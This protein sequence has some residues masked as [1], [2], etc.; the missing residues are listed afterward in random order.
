VSQGGAAHCTHPS[1]TVLRALKDYCVYNNELVS[2]H[3]AFNCMAATSYNNI[4]TIFNTAS[5][6]APH[7]PLC[8]RMLRS[9]PGPLQL[10]R[11]QSDSLTIRLDLI[12]NRLDLII[13]ICTY[14]GFRTT[15]N[16]YCSLAISV[17]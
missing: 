7:I 12:R 1:C 5:S 17:L 16:I 10:V 2:S 13:N 3:S 8:R 11:W 9:H 15:L 14:L 6:A 4:C